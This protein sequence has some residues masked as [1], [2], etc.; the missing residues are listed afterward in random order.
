[1]CFTSA[2]SPLRGPPASLINSAVTAMSHSPLITFYQNQSPDHADRFPRDIHAFSHD[3]LESHHDFIQWLFPLETPSPV[4]PFAPTHNTK[5]LHAFRTS[6]EI[7]TNLLR[8]LDLML[9][10]YG[11][12]RQPDPQSKIKNENSKIIPAPN[13]PAR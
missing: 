2:S 8:S 5:T 7:Q 1:M 9:D 11:L 3:Q 10:F 6:S 13:F 4:N 12:E